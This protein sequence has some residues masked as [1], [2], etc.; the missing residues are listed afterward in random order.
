M[1]IRIPI[2]G[3]TAV[4]CTAFTSMSKVSDITCDSARSFVSARVNLRSKT[5]LQLALKSSRFVFSWFPAVSWP[6]TGSGARRRAGPEFRATERTV[7]SAL[8]H[9]RWATPG[10]DDPRGLVNDR[11]RD[12]GGWILDSKRVSPAAMRF[13]GFAAFVLPV[14]LIEK[15][16][17]HTPD[18]RRPAALQTFGRVN[19]SHG[20]YRLPGG[21]RAPGWP[22]PP[23]RRTSGLFQALYSC[24]QQPRRRLLWTPR[25]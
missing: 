22:S 1:K 7:G 18:E 8:L 10:E 3:F 13:G 16:Y 6:P 17:V 15:R 12:H 21:K 14:F 9:Q 19:Q 24:T 11:T 23:W 4:S 25:P 2:T 5:P 20:L